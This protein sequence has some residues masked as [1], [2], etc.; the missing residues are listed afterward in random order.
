[1]RT[2][3]LNAQMFLSSF[4]E[5]GTPGEVTRNIGKYGA[6]RVPQGRSYIG[7]WALIL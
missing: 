2:H 4:L 1:M 6:N 3:H 5:M 7:T